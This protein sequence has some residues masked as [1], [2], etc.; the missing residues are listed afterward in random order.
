M[1]NFKRANATIRIMEEK[2]RRRFQFSLRTLFV[3]IT[4][5]ALWIGWSLNWIRQRQAF[6]PPDDLDQ[7]RP[8]ASST[9]KTVTAPGLLWIFGE[10]GV[11][12]IFVP[13]RQT[14]D[15]AEAKRLFPEADVRWNRDTFLF[16]NFSIPF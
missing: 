2:S 15:F 4:L 5:V 12:T 13:E 9:E 10:E 3:L 11:A 14:D 8:F 7:T 1:A 16:Q 6:L